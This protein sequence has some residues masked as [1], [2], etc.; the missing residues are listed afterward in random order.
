MRRPPFVWTRPPI[1]TDAYF[2]GKS[3]IYPLFAAPFVRLFGTNGF[4]VL[5]ALLLA[6][7]AVC[8]YLFLHARISAAGSRRCSPAAFVM[9]SVVPVYFVWITPELFNFSLAF[10][11]YFCWLY[12]EVARRERAP[13][14]TRW[15]FGG[16]QRRGRRRA[17]RH[18]DVLEGHERAAVPARW[19]R[20]CC[21]DAALG[22]QRWSLA[23]A[24]R[25]RVV[26]P[27]ASSLVN[28]AISG[29]W[30]Y[31]GGDAV[32]PSMRSSRSRTDVRRSS[33]ALPMGARRVAGRHHLRPRASSRSNLVAQPRV[34]LRRP[35][36]GLLAVFLPGGVRDRCVPA[37][38]AAAARVAVAGARGGGSRRCCSSSSTLPYT[39]MAAAARSATAISS[40]AYGV[41]LFLLPP[42][43]ATATGVR[44]LG[45]RRAVHR[46]DGPESV[47]RVVPS[48]RQRR[49]ADRCAVAGRAD[50]GQ[51]SADQHR[52]RTTRP[53][54][55]RR[56]SRP[57]RSG[58]P[59]LLPRRQ[60]LRPRE[61]TRASGCGRV[62][63]RVPDQD[64][65]GRSGRA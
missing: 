44:A 17:A 46:A 19:S 4:L 59:D 56:Q 23:G 39:W 50:A 18:R 32:A 35:V 21:G 43:D 14:G 61:R 64:A 10:L 34:L 52:S 6:L 40:A 58:V 22:E 62:A 2:Y 26:S 25:S 51:R 63:G 15:L 37:R 36:S 16:A 24:G 60:R 47:R 27:A 49:S 54:L 45:R 53:R 30:N 3:F 8:G 20:G 1:P 29:E 42:I 9:A 12:K 31:Q 33:S 5:H 48:G 7:V 41:M 13:R 38:A 55:V 11:A 28:M 57:A 65:T